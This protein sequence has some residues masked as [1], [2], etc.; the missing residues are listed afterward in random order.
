MYLSLA[1][2]SFMILILVASTNHTIYDCKCW[3]VRKACTGYN[4][5]PWPVAFFQ[6]H[7]PSCPVWEET[8]NTNV[9]YT[10]VVTSV[11]VYVYFILLY[12]FILI[13]M[14]I[15]LIGIYI[16]HTHAYWRISVC[17]FTHDPLG[18]ILPCV[19]CLFVDSAGAWRSGWSL[20]LATVGSGSSSSSN[21]AT[22][23][24]WRWD[25]SHPQIVALS[26]WWFG[27]FVFS[28]MLGMMIPSD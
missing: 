19:F 28:P 17:W 27:F 22:G 25:F 20:G 15:F 13:F 6:S 10:S 24:A 21:G 3:H 2:C 16:Y 14:F 23:T 26:G 4:F 9:S 18:W 1:V 11:H 5:G 8:T 12:M 7:N